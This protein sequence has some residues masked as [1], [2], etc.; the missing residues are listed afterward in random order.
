MEDQITCCNE[1]KVESIHTYRSID[2]LTYK[3]KSRLSYLANLKIRNLFYGYHPEHYV[4]DEINK[5]SVLKGSLDRVKKSFLH[6]QKSCLDD[7]TIQ[8]IVEK[9]N[10]IVGKESCPKKRADIKI[11]E[12]DLNSYLSKGPRCV[13]YDTWNEFSRFICGR[14][15]F[16]LTAE[17]E[18][19]DIAFEISRNI[20]SCN[21]LYSLSVYKEMCDLKYKVNRTKEEC[22]IDYKLLMEKNPTCDLEFKSYLSYVHKHNLSFPIIDEVYSSGLSLLEQ[23]GEVFLCTALNNYNLMKIAPND[24]EELLNLGFVVELNKFDI[25][26]DYKKY[27]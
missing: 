1:K 15:G 7:E 12:E 9:A 17:R 4:D 26:A 20:I 5:L 25:T 22:K 21:L 2:E 6:I 24:L 23:D 19:C 18:I 14:I 11:G 3:I 10:K 16:T 27:I 13:S 8:K